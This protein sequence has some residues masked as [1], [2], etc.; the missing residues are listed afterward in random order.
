MMFR[1]F[2]FALV[3][4]GV[5]S[6][7]PTV[8]RASSSRGKDLDPI[9]ETG[10]SKAL[11]T[12]R[13]SVLSEIHY[14]LSF[15]VPDQVRQRVSASEILTFQLKSSTQPLQIDFK[16]DLK[17]IKTLKVNKLP[18]AIN[19]LKEH[20]IIAAKSLRTGKNVVEIGFLA[21]EGALNRNRDYL[22]T[23]FVPDRA[24]TVFPCFDQPD[25]KATYTLTLTLPESWKAM[26]NAPLKD[27]ILSGGQKTHRFLESDVL[28]TY[29]FAFAAGKFDLAVEGLQSKNATFLYRETD[30]SKISRSIPEIYKIHQQSLDFYQH[31]TSIRYP[32]K[33]F[34]FVAIPDFQFGGMEH[35]GNIQ[36]KS[37]SLFLDEGATKDQRNARSNLI[38]HETAHMWFGDLVTMNWFT[39][40]WMKE[41]FANFMAD[42]SMEDSIGKEEYDLKF[43]VDHFPAA[44]TVDRTKGSNPIRQ[45]LDNLQDAGSLYGNIIYHKAPVVMRQLERLMGKGQFQSGVR[46][47]LKTYVHGNASWPDLINILNQHSR[48]DLL[49]WNKIWVNETGRPVIGYKME[50]DGNNISKLVV[51][52]K[53]EYGADRIWPQVFELTF[54]Y[55]DHIKELTVNMN[56]REVEVKNALGMEKPLFVLFNSTGLGYG[57]WPVDPAMS[58]RISSIEQPVSRASAYIA[59]YEN[60]L[61]ARSVK[62]EALFLI[63]LKDFSMEK[64]ELNLKL[65]AGYLTSIYWNFTLPADRYKLTEDL[66]TRVWAAM[67]TQTTPNNKKILFKAYQDI[68]STPYAVRKLTGIWKSQQA[69]E[70]I[71]LT[72][73]DFTAL[74]FSLALRPGAD[75][76]MLSEQLSRIK[77]PDRRSRFEF[78]T[79]ALSADRSVRDQFFKRLELRSNRAKESNVV[80][81]LA[82][83]H[84][85]LRQSTSIR[86]LGKSLE[87]LTEIQSTGDIFFPQS[88][89]QSTFGSYQNAEARKV[90]KD[91]LDGHPNYN[92]KLKSKILQAS[93]NLF[94]AESLL[95]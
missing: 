46:K 93:D 82:Y 55:P 17:T 62:P 41:V 69:P 27:T 42:K 16:E 95:Q 25:L 51:S 87:L 56:A 13:K 48:I 32:F 65:M 73:D 33:K 2:T 34:G 22:Y 28:S 15:T 38:A 18:V 44:Y 7:F 81:A 64:E 83:L 60:M 67:E 54:F 4:S 70:G 36:Y 92:P 24:R 75:S 72:E 45:D 23:L 26:S 80:A 37:S 19:L 94:R 66:E 1:A 84:H 47:Y 91:F 29:L 39:D 76:S 59:L 88:W 63:L 6:Y 85:P 21:G 14:Q 12:Y 11:A 78:I 71:K 49:S 74:A 89:L 20:L 50:V 79:P 3:F 58:G 52:Q 57:L 43:L 35:P 40:V 90:V 68:F 53:S 8:L 61:N 30:S 9:V 77:N 86:Y 5:F 10:V 31:W